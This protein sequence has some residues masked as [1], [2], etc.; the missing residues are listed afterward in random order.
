MSCIVE[1][2]GR[3]KK[4]TH[5]RGEGHKTS[6]ASRNTITRKGGR[7][8]AHFGL[9]GRE[10]ELVITVPSPSGGE[11]KERRRFRGG[12]EEQNVAAL[13][14]RFAERGKGGKSTKREKNARRKNPSVIPV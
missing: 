14:A 1:A 6:V 4:S 3:G 5:I 10:E 13:C 2:G 9:R 11:E 8:I 7:R 12:R